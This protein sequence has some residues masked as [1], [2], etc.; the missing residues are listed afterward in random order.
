[1]EKID[2]KRAAKRGYKLRWKLLMERF[3]DGMDITRRHLALLLILLVVG[4]SA[5][6]MTFVVV[7]GWEHS[8]THADFDRRLDQAMTSLNRRP[9]CTHRKGGA[10]MTRIYGFCCATLLVLLA[11]L[12]QHRA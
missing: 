9:K 2:A 12:Y 6:V 7:K 1:M 3:T 5:S 4:I 11:G 8:R 10:A